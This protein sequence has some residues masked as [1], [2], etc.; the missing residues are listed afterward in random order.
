MTH[1]NKYDLD[2]DLYCTSKWYHH[3]EDTDFSGIPPDINTLEKFME[4]CHIADECKYIF[5][6][7]RVAEMLLKQ[8]YRDYFIKYFTS[9][10]D[11]EGLIAVSTRSIMDIK[12]HLIMLLPS[13]LM[14]MD[15]GTY[16]LLFPACPAPDLTTAI[17]I[18]YHHY[19]RACPDLSLTSLNFFDSSRYSAQWV[20]LWFMAVIKRQYPRSM[21]QIIQ[22]RD[23]SFRLAC[24]ARLADNIKMSLTL[25]QLFHWTPSERKIINI[26]SPG[27]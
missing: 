3:A 26:F 21:S 22:D 9:Q 17:F 6:P 18:W 1:I 12:D 7:S 13:I 5:F 25:S 14:R 23:L 15:P 8:E 11:P 16:N 27:L 19:E 4:W 2:Y 24:M 20:D 10:Y